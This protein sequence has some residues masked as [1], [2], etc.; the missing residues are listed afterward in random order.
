MSCTS[1]LIIN[2][3]FRIWVCL[4]CFGDPCILLA[5]SHALNTGFNFLVW[6]SRFGRGSLFPDGLDARHEQ[7]PLDPI[8]VQLIGPSIRGRNLYQAAKLRVRDLRWQTLTARQAV[9]SRPMSGMGSRMNQEQR[10]CVGKNVGIPL[11]RHTP[12]SCRRASSG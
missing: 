7:L 10:I 2:Q 12:T 6:D 3:A 1:H 8:L 5:T 11:R 4:Q 9:L